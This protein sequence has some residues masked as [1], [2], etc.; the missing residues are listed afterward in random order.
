METWKDWDELSGFVK[1]K[2]SVSMVRSF[3]QPAAEGISCH[4]VMAI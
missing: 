3:H 1:V 2:I 4:S